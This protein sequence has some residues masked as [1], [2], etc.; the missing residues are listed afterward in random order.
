MQATELELYDRSVKYQFF[1]MPQEWVLAQQIYIYGMDIEMTDDDD[2]DDDDEILKIGIMGEMND[3]LLDG[4][5]RLAL[6]GL[7]QVFDVISEP[8]VLNEDDNVC[9]FISTTKEVKWTVQW[10]P[11]SSSPCLVTEPSTKIARI[12]PVLIDA[13]TISF[14]FYRITLVRF[15]CDGPVDFENIIF[16]NYNGA[17]I[18]V[19]FDVLPNNNTLLFRQ[20]YIINEDV[21]W[22]TLSYQQQHTDPST[23]SGFYVICVRD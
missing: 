8:F 21:I 2:D 15:L 23:F 20:E 13:N 19:R 22:L 4:P 6:D 5:K 3:M 7:R 1:T 17:V 10:M 12:Q 16:T 14:P 11:A 9:L 18:S